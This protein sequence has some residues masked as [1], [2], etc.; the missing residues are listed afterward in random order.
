MLA[1]NASNNY[2]TNTIATGIN[3][4]DESQSSFGFEIDASL[5]AG[6]GTGVGTVAIPLAQ[7]DDLS[8]AG[9]SKQININGTPF[10]A[11]SGN[12]AYARQSG[13]TIWR[14]GTDADSPCADAQVSVV[15]NFVAWNFTAN[16]YF[17]YSSNNVT[18]DRLILRG[19]AS[20]LNH[21]Y[22][23]VTGVARRAWPPSG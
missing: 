15:K 23:I 20:Q 21:A 13:M 18:V 8:Q 16:G 5:G 10:P 9:Q 11:F 12:E 3:G 17:G 7:G 14:I 22:S 19:D 1:L 6:G 2:I 4:G